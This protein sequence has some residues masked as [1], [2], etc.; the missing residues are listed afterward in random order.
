M[1]LRRSLM[2]AVAALPLL[3][4]CGGDDDPPP[5]APVSIVA[6]A[7]ADPRFSTLVEALQAAG[8]V[9]ALSGAGPFTVFAPTNDAFAALLTELGVTKEQLFAD[10]DALANVLQ[11]HVLDTRVA[12]SAVQAGKPITPLAGGYFKATSGSGGLGFQDASNRTGRITQTDIAATNGVIHV[13]DTVML[14]TTDTVVDVAQSNADF[15]ILVEAVVAAGLVDTLSGEGPFTVF[16]PTNA[17]F[18]ALLTELGVTKDELLADTAT[19]TAV[20]TYHVVPSLVLAAD[21]PVGAPITTVQSGTFSVSS[22]L[23]ITD[24]R[25]RTANITATDVFAANG[26]VHVIDKVILPP[27]AN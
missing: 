27:V 25:G 10:T 20:L 1:I 12:S 6:T 16:A 26:V 18:A 17:A 7:Q 11:Y 21:V 15:S 24:G 22:A 23:A 3:A 9:S 2:A 13:L 4:A 19:L 5:P 14:P 8:L